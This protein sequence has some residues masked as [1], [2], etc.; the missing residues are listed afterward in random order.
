MFFNKKI[1]RGV[2]NIGQF[3]INTVFNMS[4]KFI[5]KKSYN[6]NKNNKNNKNNK[7]VK[8]NNNIDNNQYIYK[9]IIYYPINLICKTLNNSLKIIVNNASIIGKKNKINILQ[10]IAYACPIHSPTNLIL[11]TIIYSVN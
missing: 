6:V 5:R 10:I 11:R 2:I 9:T 7:M 1:L 8:I 3:I 4:K